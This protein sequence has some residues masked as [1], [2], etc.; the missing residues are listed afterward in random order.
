VFAKER[1]ESKWL[2]VNDL[3]REVLALVRGD[4]ASQGIRL[5]CELSSELPDI[6]ADR[7]PLQQVLLNLVTNAADALTS[8]AD[9]ERTL[10]V[11]TWVSDSS[12]MIAVEE[13]GNGY[14]A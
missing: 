3:I 8:V 6:M 2:N 11:K 7:I 5:Q 14:Q 10:M 4:L 12:V 9:R 1:L 13:L